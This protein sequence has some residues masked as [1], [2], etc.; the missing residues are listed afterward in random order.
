VPDIIHAVASL[1]DAAN[2]VPGE[3]HP[4]RTTWVRARL[5]ALLRGRTADVVTALVAVAA[6]P[7]RSVVQQAAIARTARYHRR[8]A[9]YV[10]HDR[11]LARGWPIGT[12][13]I[14]SARGRLVTDRMEQA[15]MRRTRDGAHAILDPRAVRLTDDRDACRASHRERQHHRL[16]AT[17]SALP[18]APEAH[19]LAQHAAA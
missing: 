12:G 17:A 19:A 8:T 4:A 6:E 10:H 9:P 1:R 18:L 14:E 2:A 7:T 3:R 11:S 5:L 13:V 16:Y 15:G